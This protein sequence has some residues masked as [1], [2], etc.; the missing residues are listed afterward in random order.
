MALKEKAF[1][2]IIWS[3]IQK[4]GRQGISFFV[5]AVLARFLE[6]E[7]FGQMAI[8]VSFTVFANLFAEQGFSLAIIQK[9]KINKSLID[10]VFT[11]ISIISILLFIVIYLSSDLLASLFSLPKLSEYLKVISV[12]ILIHPL[13]AVPLAILRRKLEFKKIAFRTLIASLFG[14]IIGI[15]MAIKGFG[16]WSLIGKYTAESIVNAFLLVWFSHWRPRL[17]INHSELKYLF[18]FGINIL[19][20]TLLKR[21]RF[22][23]LDLAIGYFLG[24]TLLGYY[25]VAAKLYNSVFY[26]ISNTISSVI[27]PVYSRLQSDIN[28]IKAAYYFTLKISMIVT[29]PAFFLLII[30]SKELILLAFGEKWSQSS[31]ILQIFGFWGILQ[32]L[33]NLNEGLFI[34]LSEIY[35]KFKYELFNFT[36]IVI[37]FFIFYKN[38]L[39]QLLS[40][41]V[42]IS[43][44]VVLL[45]IFRISKLLQ[46]NVLIY[47]KQIRSVGLSIVIS[48]TLI[49]FLSSFHFIAPIFN[50]ILMALFLLVYF[51]IIVL[52]E[53]KVLLSFIHSFN[54]K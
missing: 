24:T 11:I 15:F 21:L 13:I 29:A 16:I 42:L 9:E 1:K 28:K 23:F 5:F 33:Q 22:Q 39:T 3:S 52:F 36:L 43:L 7:D 2:A 32:S 40:I 34:A 17:I 14:G 44:I 54:F 31:Q 19:G 48:G 26:F 49:Y 37:S 6:A 18:G 12:S 45:E 53:K 41:L 35:I 47:L 50:Y 27:I 4:F 20:I 30:F 25:S 46:T 8:I 10:T 51:L 38:G